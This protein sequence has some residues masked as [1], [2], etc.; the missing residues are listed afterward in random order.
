MTVPRQR[1][2]T[3][4]IDGGGIGNSNNRDIMT[5][6]RDVRSPRARDTDYRKIIPLRWLVVGQDSP[7]CVSTTPVVVVIAHSIY[8]RV[9]VP[10]VFEHRRA[11]AIRSM[12]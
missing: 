1:R 9:P 10:R 3:A 4:T 12:R 11:R 2:V 8:E 7:P 6:V 5:S